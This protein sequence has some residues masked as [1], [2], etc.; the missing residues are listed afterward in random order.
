MMLSQPDLHYANPLQLP[1]ALKGLGQK[2]K[3]KLLGE[4]WGEELE[5]IVHILSTEPELPA[6]P[7]HLPD[8]LLLMNE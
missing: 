6:K 8:D 4:G 2:L 5:G 1:R 3:D 7:Q